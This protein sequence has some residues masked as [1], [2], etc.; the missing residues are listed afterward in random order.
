MPAR[1]RATRDLT[2][3]SFPHGKSAGYQRGCT[4]DEDCPTTPTCRVVRNRQNKQN[5]VNRDRGR[6]G[7][8]M[9]AAGVLEHDDL[10][11]AAVPDATYNAYATLA[12]VAP[13]CFNHM[14]ESGVTSPRTATALLHVTPTAL[15]A[16]T[17]VVD[18]DR[19]RHLL[20]Q[21]QAAGYS[22]A[23]V[24]ERVTTGSLNHLLIGPGGKRHTRYCHRRTY[25]EVRAVF[26]ATGGR[27]ADPGR[28]GVHPVGMRVAQA[29]ARR[30]GYTVEAAYDQSV[31][32]D[33][34][35]V[36]PRSIPNH[37]WALA[38]DYA[39]YLLDFAYALATIGISE[40]QTAARA[41]VAGDQGESAATRMTCRRIISRLGLRWIDEHR[42]ELT[43]LEAARANRKVLDRIKAA[44]WAYE[45]A[46]VGPVTAALDLRLLNPNS[47]GSAGAR[48]KGPLVP[49]DHPELVAWNA[50]AAA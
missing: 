13:S 29:A 26:E 31:V 43:P 44:Y 11:L 30:A 22:L 15:A 49:A 14:R 21:L 7:R 23:W 33:V 10:V 16:A 6:S 1:P 19:V 41:Q 47:V 28:D 20:R 25:E 39:A 32:G 2:D 9:A 35:T 50:R 42:R 46:E 18:A 48:G 45:A 37:P 8:A 5:K 27:V 38:D 4:R 36:D 17:G 3:P 34:V 24:Q 12:G 40:N